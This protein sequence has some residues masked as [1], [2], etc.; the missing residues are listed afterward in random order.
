MR[1]HQ[2]ALT[3]ARRPV[4]QSLNVHSGLAIA[5]LA[6]IGAL[7]L[8]GCTGGSESANPT[9]SPSASPSASPTT[10]DAAN[11]GVAAPLT[12]RLTFGSVDRVICPVPGKYG[13]A[14]SE[15][16]LPI[17]SVTICM[18]KFYQP[19]YTKPVTI[20]LTEPWQR[21]Q[22]KTFTMPDNRSLCVD[23]AIDPY[24]VFVNTDSGTYLVQLPVDGCGTTL[25]KVRMALNRLVTDTPSGKV[26][27]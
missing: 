15:E 16:R 9:P 17:R 14:I 6:V 10:P 19:D 13:D 4:A 22:V 26:E 5:S 2:R 25:E 27:F 8:G 21:Q 3:E 18:P 12:L 1:A 7:I 11:E 23:T 24:R 20:K